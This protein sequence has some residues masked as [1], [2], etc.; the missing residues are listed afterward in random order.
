MVK[1]PHNLKLVLL[2]AAQLPRS[3]EDVDFS[4]IN[5]NF[6]ASS[7]IPFS[8]GLFLER[9]YRLHQLGGGQER[10]CGQASFAKDGGGRLQLP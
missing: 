2:E 1:N 8:S 6:A 4:V 10:R 3:R 9:S 7:G 5:G